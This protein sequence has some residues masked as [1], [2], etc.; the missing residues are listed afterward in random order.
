MMDEP[1]DEGRLF[2]EL[3]TVT[4]INR[5]H[6]GLETLSTCTDWHP[7]LIRGGI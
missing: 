7:R 5:V 1:G 2:G 4:Q 6:N 3:S